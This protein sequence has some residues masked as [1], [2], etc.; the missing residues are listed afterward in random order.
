MRVGV[1]TSG[2]REKRPRKARVWLLVV[3]IGTASHDRPCVLAL[4][5]LIGVGLTTNG[6][7]GGLLPL[8]SLIILCFFSPSLLYHARVP[9]LHCLISNFELNFRQ[10]F[11]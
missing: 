5:F 3:A 9:S 6:G 10:L 4:T 7:L 1:A 8:H 2:H 11:D